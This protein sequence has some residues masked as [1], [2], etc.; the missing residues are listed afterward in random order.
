MKQ[1]QAFFKKLQVGQFLIALILGISLL[2]TACSTDRLIAD[3]SAS[4]AAP[5][6]STSKIKDIPNLEQVD[7]GEFERTVG[8]VPSEHKPILINPDNPKAKFLN[9]REGE[10]KDTSDLRKDKVGKE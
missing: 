2:T 5:E 8:D 4:N 7:Y 6:N 10:V 3:R 1:L 9:K